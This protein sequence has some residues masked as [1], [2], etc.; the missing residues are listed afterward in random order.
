[1]TLLSDRPAKANHRLEAYGGVRAK[2]CLAPS[3]GMA[4]RWFSGQL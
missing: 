4:G 1:L 3:V 2:A